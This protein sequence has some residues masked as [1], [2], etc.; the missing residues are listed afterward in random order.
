MKRIKYVYWQDGD[1]WLGYLEEYPDYQTQGESR[2]ELKE[3]LKDIYQELTSGNIPCIR[4]VAELEV[5]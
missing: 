4:K 1:T 3:N 2:E 5:A